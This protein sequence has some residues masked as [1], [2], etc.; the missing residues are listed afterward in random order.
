MFPFPV[1]C[2][3][4]AVLQVLHRA[5]SRA[6]GPA[7]TV[8]DTVPS[9]CRRRTRRGTHH[10]TAR[11]HQLT[12]GRPPAQRGPGGRAAGEIRTFLVESVSRTG[13]HLGPNLGVVELTI[14]MHRVFESPLDTMVFDTGHQ[15]YVHKLLT[16]R[17]DFSKLRARDGLSGLPEPHRV[18]RTTSWRTRTRR[19]R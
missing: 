14:A 3:A 9:Q 13:G 10:G 1:D 16:G 11:P 7:S 6:V 4:R 8:W 2:S 15:A 19:R 18:G 17:T 5:C 12:G